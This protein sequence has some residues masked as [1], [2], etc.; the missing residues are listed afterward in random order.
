MPP[1][2]KKPLPEVP[3]A[4]APENT[5][6]GGVAA[7]TVATEMRSSDKSSATAQA[8]KRTETSSETDDPEIPD[9]PSPMPEDELSEK[10]AKFSSAERS[11]LRVLYEKYIA[12]ETQKWQE[13][14]LRLCGIIGWKN[15]P[16]PETDGKL[17]P[18]VSQRD[19]A[20]IISE[21]FKTTV[22]HD[23]L[24]K[25][26]KAKVAWVALCVGSGNRWK[27]NITL[28][29]WEENM[30]DKKDYE[31][32]AELKREKLRIDNETAAMER[33]KLKREMDATWLKKAD[34]QTTVT[35]AVLLHHSFVKKTFKEF[36]GRFAAGI[37]NESQIQQIKSAFG[38]MLEE[39]E[40]DCETH[41]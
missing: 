16:D 30:G 7:T 11:N 17:P 37:F 8:R 38:K 3:A 29:L 10:L 19:M 36:T 21:Q 34:A 1:R 32:D 12:G 31:T 26:R 15:K 4:A 20:K 18:E 14:K 39:I 25:M 27:P 9:N 22:L 13:E 24:S 40:T 5:F 35:A 2:T 33:D 28:R 6:V 23:T 41:K